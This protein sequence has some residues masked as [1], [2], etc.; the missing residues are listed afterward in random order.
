MRFI[1]PSLRPMS[2]L[3]KLLYPKTAD[4]RPEQFESPLD[5]LLAKNAGPK[6]IG[7]NRC[8]G[9]EDKVPPEEQRHA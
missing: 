5:D 8:S 3:H 7:E 9:Y 1:K 6:D 2:K 4:A